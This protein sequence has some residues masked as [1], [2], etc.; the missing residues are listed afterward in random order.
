MTTLSS[1]ILA[2]ITKTLVKNI[3]NE[4][5]AKFNLNVDEVND[6]FQHFLSN[7]L[8]ITKTIKSSNTGKGRI[9]GYILFSGEMRK[10][11][12]E[13]DDT[14]TFIEIG[15][16][17]GKLWTQ[18]SESEKNEWRDKAY[19]KNEENGIVSIETKKKG[20]TKTTTVKT[21][22]KKSMAINIP[23]KMELTKESSTNT[24]LIKDTNL[25][26]ESLKNKVVIGQLVGKKLK[27]LSADN[28]KT[29]TKNDWPMKEEE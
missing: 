13:S 20:T 18:L 23:V 19:L 29:C 2:I 4:A 12:R 8:N 10:T 16:K 15:K 11:L 21:T 27:A 6:F 9:S 1:Q 7:E 28:I 3:P 26:V 22:G 14:I 24:W 5:A 25:A 17:L